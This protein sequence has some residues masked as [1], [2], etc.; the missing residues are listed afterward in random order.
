MKWGKKRNLA[1]SVAVLLVLAGVIVVLFALRNQFL[2]ADGATL[3]SDVP[4]MISLLV[5][6][7]FMMFGGY[8]V[9]W[10]FTS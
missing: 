1:A 4:S 6:G 9:F 8:A 2:Q 3:I 10:Y 5:F 7:I